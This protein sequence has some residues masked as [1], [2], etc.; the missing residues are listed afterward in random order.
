MSLIHKI[1]AIIDNKSIDDITFFD[2]NVV[3]HEDIDL[4]D[5]DWR[6]MIPRQPLNSSDETEKELRFISK[7]TLNRSTREIDLIY[8]VD[9]NPLY[10]FYEFIDPK[11]LILPKNKFDTFYNI[12]EQYIYALKIHFNRARPFQ[13]AKV[14][15]INIDVLNTDTH[16]TPAYPSG[17]TMYAALAAHILTDLYPEFEKKFFQLAESCGMARIMQGVHFPSDNKASFLATKVLYQNIKRLEYE[18]GTNF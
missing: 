16:H 13:L 3:Y 2:K 1:A 9:A 15:N 8:K 12:I 7:Q 14:Y 18:K 11:G 6:R 5:I 10:L 4:L 17:H